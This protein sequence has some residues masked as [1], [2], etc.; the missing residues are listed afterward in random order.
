MKEYRLSFALGQILEPAVALEL[1]H[2][3]RQQKLMISMYP[4]NKMKTV[5]DANDGN[6]RDE[7]V[8]LVGNTLRK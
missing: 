6:Q 1:A 5:A 4:L 8:V 7:R 3:L 2:E